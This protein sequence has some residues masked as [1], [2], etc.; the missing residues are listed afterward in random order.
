MAITINSMVILTGFIESATLPIALQLEQAGF[1]I[2]FEG[3]NIDLTVYEANG[4]ILYNEWRQNIEV[5]R[6]NE[7]S[8]QDNSMTWHRPVGA[9]RRVIS[10]TPFLEKFQD[11]VL[12]HDPRCCLTM[13]MWHGNK[14]RVIFVDSDID[15]LLPTLQSLYGL[16]AEY[17]RWLHSEYT[18]AVQ[19]YLKKALV[20]QHD[21]VVQNA[22]W[23]EK[24]T[25]FTR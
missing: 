6:I 10:P 12:I 2:L 15:T 8:L 19:P 11:R 18:A 1:P 24:V 3:Q 25:E 7:G 16:N 17:W 14:T 22:G 9:L 20:L 4:P 21:D 5:L 23:S 13:G